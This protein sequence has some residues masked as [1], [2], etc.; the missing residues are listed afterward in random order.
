MYA[1][2]NQVKRFKPCITVQKKKL[3]PQLTVKYTLSNI[4][5]VL[6]NT[7]FACDLMGQFTI[8]LCDFDHQADK[9]IG[10]G[11]AFVVKRRLENQN[12]SR[13]RWD[14]ESIKEIQKKRALYLSIAFIISKKP[15]F[16]NVTLSG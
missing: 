6:E 16:L 5:N 2:T 10:V 9:E 14:K 7:T 8:M 15:P 1:K 4:V 12:M 3:L 13:Q 11:L